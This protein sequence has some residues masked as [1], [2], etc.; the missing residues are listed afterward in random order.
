MMLTLETLSYIHPSFGNRRLQI[1]NN[2]YETIV[3]SMGVVIIKVEFHLIFH[4]IF[5]NNNFQ[6]YLIF[7]FIADAAVNAVIHQKFVIMKT[8]TLISIFF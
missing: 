7:F 5:S 6:T 8:G 1:F 4:I 2:H 3:V